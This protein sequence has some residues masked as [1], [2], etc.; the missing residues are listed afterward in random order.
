MAVGSRG[1]HVA[2]DTA[3]GRALGWRLA[4]G[5][6]DLDGDCTPSSAIARARDHAACGWVAHKRLALEH[7]ACSGE[8]DAGERGS[9]KLHLHAL[10]SVPEDS[11]HR[12]AGMHSYSCYV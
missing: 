3:K 4:T 2:L 9:K 10:R 7:H 8:T 1:N 5:V 6:E 12:V 11:N